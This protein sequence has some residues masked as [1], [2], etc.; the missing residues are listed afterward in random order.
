MKSS[1]FPPILSHTVGHRVQLRLPGAGAEAVTGWGWA[2]HPSGRSILVP[3]LCVC[4]LLCCARLSPIPKQ[5]QLSESCTAAV[6]LW[7]GGLIAWILTPPVLLQEGTTRDFRASDR[8]H[9]SHY[10]WHLQWQWMC[11]AL[12]PFASAPGLCVC[13]VTPAPDSRALVILTQVH[14]KGEEA[15]DALDKLG[16]LCLC[17]QIAQSPFSTFCFLG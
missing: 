10:S 12:I 13:I 17:S 3:S 6:V 16:H 5:G 4:P 14:G 15:G 2:P 8:F 9:T 1:H 11:P 7:E